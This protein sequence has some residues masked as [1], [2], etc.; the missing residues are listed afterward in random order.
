MYRLSVG[1]EKHLVVTSHLIGSAIY[2]WVGPMSGE[3]V[4]YSNNAEIIIIS[5]THDL[6]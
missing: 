2:E 4:Y 1:N 5:V 6:R 3:D